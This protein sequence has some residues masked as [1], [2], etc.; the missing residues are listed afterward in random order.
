MYSKMAKNKDMQFFIENLKMN[1]KRTKFFLTYWSR[2]SNSR[3][4]V[5]FPP[6][7]SIFMQGEG[8]EIKSKQASKRDRTLTKKSQNLLSRGSS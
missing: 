5:I 1:R 8:D 4:S 3:F 7:I 2:D 6:M